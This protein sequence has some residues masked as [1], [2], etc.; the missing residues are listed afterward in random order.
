MKSGENKNSKK[1]CNLS[2]FTRN[3]NT[4]AA[5]NVIEYIYFFL[6]SEPTDDKKVVKKITHNFLKIFTNKGSD[7]MKSKLTKI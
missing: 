7:R 5:L 4:R 2:N 3:K 6:N 1:G